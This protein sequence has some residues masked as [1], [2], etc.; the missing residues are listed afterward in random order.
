M[1]S[2]GNA[3]ERC[4]TLGRRRVEGADGVSSNPYGRNDS[5]PGVPRKYGIETL[6]GVGCYRRGRAHC[7]VTPLERK[8]IYGPANTRGTRGAL[9]VRW[10]VRRG[11]S[12]GIRPTGGARGA[13][14]GISSAFSRPASSGCE[15]GSGVCTV[16]EDPR[17][18]SCTSVASPQTRYDIMGE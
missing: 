8:W 7:G 15:K 18:K 11:V 6:P 9:S 4:E 5:R 13:R 1:S 16:L 10:R 12:G 2:S 14:L 17:K 3:S